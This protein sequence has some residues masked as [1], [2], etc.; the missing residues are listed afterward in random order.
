MHVCYLPVTL[1]LPELS[2][3]TRRFGKNLQDL[4]PLESLNM[5]NVPLGSC[6]VVDFAGFNEVPCED[7]KGVRLNPKIG[8]HGGSSRLDFTRMHSSWHLASQSPHSTHGMSLH[9]Q[10]SMYTCSMLHERMG[11]KSFR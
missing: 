11:D 5:K 8:Q 6:T 9:S 3:S 10:G 7:A 1:T 2:K 4:K